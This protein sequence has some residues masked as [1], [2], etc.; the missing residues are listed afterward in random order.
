MRVVVFNL[1]I[2]ILCL[3]LDNCLFEHLFGKDDGVP[4]APNPG[5]FRRGLEEKKSKNML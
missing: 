2:I 5:Q 1:V 3:L 4:R